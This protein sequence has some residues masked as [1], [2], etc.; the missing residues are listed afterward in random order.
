M[1]R[2][3]KPIITDA[4]G[5]RVPPHLAEDFTAVQEFDALERSLLATKAELFALASGMGSRGAERYRAFAERVDALA[6][7]L[8]RSCRPFAL[9]PRCHGDQ[10]PACEQ[11]GFVPEDLYERLARPAVAS[12]GTA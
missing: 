12:G 11:I 4:T 3:P 8:R 7:L 2:K 6:E 10:C 1:R 9:R 5:A